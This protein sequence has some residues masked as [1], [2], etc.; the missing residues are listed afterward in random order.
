MS[1]LVGNPEDRFSGVAA[2]L[3]CPQLKA[4]HYCNSFLMQNMKTPI[5]L[6]RMYTLSSIV[7]VRIHHLDDLRTKRRNSMYWNFIFSLRINDISDR[8]L[9]LQFL[10]ILAKIPD[11]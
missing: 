6:K 11:N 4:N 5:K 3:I 8:R 1:D 10:S 2:Q 7:P 9:G